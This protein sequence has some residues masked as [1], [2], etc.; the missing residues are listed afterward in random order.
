MADLRNGGRLRIFRFPMNNAASGSPVTCTHGA[1]SVLVDAHVHLHECFAPSLFLDAAA[2]NMAECARALGLPAATPG[3]LLLTE[4]SGADAFSGLATGALATG[5]WRIEPLPESVSL[6]AIAED[7]PALVL[8]GGRQIVTAEG[9]EVLA[10]G[11]RKSFVDGK[12]LRSVLAAV[13]AAGA[14]PVIPWG[15]GKWTGRRGRI[16]R[17]ILR[18]KGG[19]RVHLGDNGGRP[20]G[21]R[22][23]PLFAV[24]ETQGSWV[25]PGTD[26]L[27]F[28][29][30]VAKPGR[31]GFLA[32]P[33][34]DWSEP[35][36]SLKR[37]LRTRNR[38]PQTY[39]R[40]ESPVVFA[41]RQAA[42]QIVKRRRP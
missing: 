8:V 26:P 5:A 30:E 29:G 16:V 35:F 15:F 11:T 12:P 4:S 36:A 14:I 27:P 9:L 32:E 24:A 31:Y 20:A 7:R 25:L 18:E 3:F 37:W 28:A 2:A 42:M 1:I 13:D 23:P 6:R 33:E 34:L 10:L 41:W 22:R 19:H 39:G 21:S 40:L 38:A 17:G